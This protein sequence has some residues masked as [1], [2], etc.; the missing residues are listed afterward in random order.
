MNLQ[1]KISRIIGNGYYDFKFSISYHSDWKFCL[2]ALLINNEDIVIFLTM[3]SNLRKSLS[4]KPKSNKIQIQYEP[5]LYSS[6]FPSFKI[7]IFGEYSDRKRQRS[8]NWTYYILHSHMNHLQQAIVVVEEPTCARQLWAKVEVESISA[9][10]WLKWKMN[11]AKYIYWE[12]SNQPLNQASLSYKPN[13]NW[14]FSV[15]VPFLWLF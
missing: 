12:V 13:I 14:Q 7:F 6:I 3:I 15:G 2:Q 11:L 1:R 10:V 8:L 5:L 9:V 4:I